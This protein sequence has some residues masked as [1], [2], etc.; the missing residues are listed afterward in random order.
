MKLKNFLIR[1][2]SGYH[3]SNPYHNNIHASDVTQAAFSFLTKGELAQY[4]FN[5]N[6]RHI[7]FYIVL[8]ALTLPMLL[9]MQDMLSLI[10]AC[11][12]HDY[13]HPGF[14]NAFLVNT[15]D[16]KAIRYND[17][18]VLENHHCS[19][20]FEVTISYTSSHDHGVLLLT[21]AVR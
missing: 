14:N 9:T 18:S 13:D 7:P 15:N 2:E 5:M 10:L 6:D 16:P 17:I 21:S 11:L 12:I 3:P 4:P 20:A 19:A 8:V 1:V